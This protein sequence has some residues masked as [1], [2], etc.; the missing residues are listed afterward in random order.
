MSLNNVFCHVEG[1]CEAFFED[2][3]L[4]PPKFAQ[5]FDRACLIDI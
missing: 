1:W 3:S 2:L 5:S 4:V